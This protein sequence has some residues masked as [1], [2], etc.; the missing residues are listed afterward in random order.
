MNSPVEERLR[1]ALAEAGAT[2]DPDTLRP[3]RAPARG[4][5]RMNVRL[6]AAGAVAVLA[7]A[8][9]V[10][11]LGTGLGGTAGQDHV[12]AIAPELAEPGKAD[13]TVFMC[14]AS[15]MAIPEPRCQ[16]REATAEEVR[17][18]E[19]V[20]AGLPEVQASYTVDRRLAY[21]G[22]RAQYV[23]NRAI[24]D[25]VKVT[26]LP[27]AIRLTV[28][29]ERDR[30]K[31]EKAFRSVPGVMAVVDNTASE[32]EAAAAREPETRLNVFLCGKEAITASCGAESKPGGDAPG[33]VTIT[34]PGKAVTIAQKKAIEELIKGMPGVQS[35][36]FEDQRAA[37]ENFRRQ[38]AS[39]KRLLD[40]TKVT[41]MPESF[42]V[43][44]KPEADWTR[45]VAALRGQPGV[46][47]V[48][49]LPCSTA[50]LL[51]MYRYGL[52][53]P[54]GTMCGQGGNNLPAT[55]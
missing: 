8:T 32:R 54:D 29:E 41:D 48:F 52:N 49:H 38:F 18:A 53:L 43:V 7:A 51:V 10:V 31:V 12:A 33:G 24:L 37:Y 5:A 40:A 16:G 4:R 22:F 26:D 20:V 19:R 28:R 25:L 36:T 9:A 47:S 55:P 35:F 13:M 23:G 6:V 15:A 3:L 17:E 45:V 39:N 11:G 42:R 50:G 1:A 2:I 44:L 14:S 34:K 30:R 27:V 21:D 46:S